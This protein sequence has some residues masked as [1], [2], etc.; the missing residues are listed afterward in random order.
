MGHLFDMLAQSEHMAECP[1]GTS[2]AF[3]SWSHRQH[4]RSS[5]SESLD[6]SLV[7]SGD[8]V[9]VSIIRHCLNYVHKLCSCGKLKSNHT[10]LCF[11]G[12]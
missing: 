12:Y 2:S 8:L 11:C 7:V 3:T 10:P 4:S 9:S 1:H 6:D 5:E